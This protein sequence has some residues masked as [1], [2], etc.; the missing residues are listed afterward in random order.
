MDTYDV[1][2]QIWRMLCDGP[3]DVGGGDLVRDAGAAEI[4]HDLTDLGK[5]KIKSNA[6]VGEGGGDKCVGE[7]RIRGQR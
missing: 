1:S 5:V 2:S 7:R 4:L 3:E 6:L